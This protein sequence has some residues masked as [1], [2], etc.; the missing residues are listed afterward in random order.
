MNPDL[1][2]IRESSPALDM[3]HIIKHNMSDH[4]LVALERGFDVTSKNDAGT[5]Y[6]HLCILHKNL[7]FAQVFLNTNP[8]VIDIEDPIKNT[9]LFI[10]VR[11]GSTK[12]L[13]FLLK[14]DADIYHVN[15]RGW[16]IIH[17]AIG[18]STKIA[19]ILIAAGVDRDVR[20]LFTLETAL[21]MAVRIHDLDMIRCLI[22]LG[23]EINSQTAL[24]I[25]PTHLALIERDGA[26]YD[27]LRSHGGRCVLFSPSN[28][29]VS[30]LSPEARIRYDV[31]EQIVQGIE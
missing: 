3:E 11:M 30:S 17:Q 5:P 31:C 9:A 12:I 14:N 16:S 26:S 20:A 19:E 24:G 15:I 21:H 18:Q 23:V 28:D 8:E 4:L 29:F 27:L 6:F 1:H 13:R 22:A 2:R 7:G 25:T 10:A